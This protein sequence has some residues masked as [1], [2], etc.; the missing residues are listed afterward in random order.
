MLSKIKIAAL[1]VA[2]TLAAGSSVAARAGNSPRLEEP[3]RQAI[4]IRQKTQKGE[5]NWRSEKEQLT[6]EFEQLTQE[7]DNLQGK[8]RKLR[9]RNA[10]TRK[11]I[12][13][14]KHQLEDINQISRQIQPF[15][16]NQVAELKS[17][18]E[19]DLPFLTTERKQRVQ[20]LENLM[21]APEVSISEKYRKVMEALLVEAEYGFTIEALQDTIS[22][23]GRDRLVNIFRLG[24]LNLFYQSLDQKECGFY[25]VADRAWQPL[26]VRYNRDI[27]SALAIAGKQQPA[28]LLKLPLGRMVNR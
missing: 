11:R 10:V 8:V 19:N 22:I 3:V 2:A 5:E 20:K 28:E 25:N 26:A 1:V 21:T 14:K 13:L 27:Q 4:D 12:A 9:E 24:R 23:A 6:A 7:R 16:E 17:S 15:L 18:I